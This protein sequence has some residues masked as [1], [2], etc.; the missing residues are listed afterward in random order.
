MYS[1]LC[2]LDNY[3]VL[4]EKQTKLFWHILTSR[5]AENFTVQGASKI[6][7]PDVFFHTHAKNYNWNIKSIV[8][9]PCNLEKE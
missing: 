2:V 7:N 8:S 9:S 1:K 4:E 5:K 3:R 6:G